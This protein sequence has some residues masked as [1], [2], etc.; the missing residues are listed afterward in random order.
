M[1]R[2]R[3]NLRAFWLR[4]CGALRRGDTQQDFDAEIESH[5]AMHTEEALRGGL[6]INEARRKA[7][8]RL[9]GAEQARKTWPDRRTLAWLEGLRQDARFGRRILVR[10]RPLTAVGIRT[11]ESGGG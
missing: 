7:L 2:L 9:G 11:R 1:D 3:A 5:I 8:L 6:N 10:N 4:L